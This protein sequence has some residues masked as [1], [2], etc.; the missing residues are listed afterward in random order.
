VRDDMG[1]SRPLALEDA[2]LDLFT[3][4]Q[5][6]RLYWLKAFKWWRAALFAR[7]GS[8]QALNADAAR[9]RYLA[10]AH[11]IDRQMRVYRS[12]DAFAPLPS[13]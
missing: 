2:S 7:G 4:A 3:A 5:L 6:R 11:E 12:T 13:P 10:D 1:L 9:A 8:D